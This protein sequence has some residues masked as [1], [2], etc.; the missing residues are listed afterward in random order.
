MNQS[1]CNHHG[2]MIDAIFPVR[3]IQFRPDFVEPPGLRV[4]VA[5]KFFTNLLTH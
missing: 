2:Y 5:R 4:I 1:M 3:R